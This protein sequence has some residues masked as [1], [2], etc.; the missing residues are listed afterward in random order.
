MTDLAHT[1]TIGDAEFDCTVSFTITSHGSP[2]HMGS[3]TY[4]GD[5]GDPPEWEIEGIVR[6][7]D[8]STIDYDELTTDQQTKLDEAICLCIGESDDDYYDEPEY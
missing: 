2:P 7:G 5:P 4:P 6:D 3:L 1:I 8:G